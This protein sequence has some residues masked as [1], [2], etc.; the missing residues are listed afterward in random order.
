MR[1]NDVDNIKLV[2]GPGLCNCVAQSQAKP[3]DVLA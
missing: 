3:S 1:Y 2:K